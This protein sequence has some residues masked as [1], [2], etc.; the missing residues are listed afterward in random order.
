MAQ[1][2]IDIP[3]PSN[4][5]GV[6][7]LDTRTA[8]VFPDGYLVLSASWTAPDDRY[9][10]AFQALPWAEVIFR[11]AIV[12]EQFLYDRS[13]DLKIRLA[14]ES[15]YRP[16]L[17]LGFQ[18]VL[19]TGV[20]AGEYLVVSKRWRD[21]D[22]S[23]GVGWGRLGSSGTFGNPF[24][25][26]SDS[27]LTRKGFTGQGGVPLVNAW[28]HGPDVGIFGGISYQ[29]PIKNLTFKVEYT[30]DRYTSEK[31]NIGKDFSFPVNVG[32]SYRPATWL[33]LGVSLMHGRYLGVRLSTLVDPTSENWQARIDP[34]PRF[35]ARPEEPA[36]TL[37]QGEGVP[38]DSGAGAP[39]TRFIDL[40]A[41]PPLPPGPSLQS[42]VQAAPTASGRQPSSEP[43]V[44]GDA[45]ADAAL[46]DLP[47]LPGFATPPAL[48]PA[49]PLAVGGSALDAASFERIRMGLDSQ[50]L[51][52][53]GAGLE[54]DKLVVL[55]ENT[56]Y[57][58]D[59]DAISRTARI[60][61]GAAL[62][63]VEYF[64]ITMLR[65]GQ[66]LTTVTFP[67]NEIDKLAQRESSPAELFAA[68]QLE[69]ANSARLD[70]LQMNL[71]PQF[72]GQIY[73]VFRQSLFDPDQPVYMRFAVGA[74]E[75]LRLSRGWFIEASGIATIYD[76]FDKIKRQTNSELPHVRS[77]VV[78]YLQEGAVGME[79]F[80][81]SYFFKLAP[82]IFGRVTGGYLEQ[83]FAGV[84]GE[85]LY[86]PF[87]QRWAVGAD[88]FFVQQRDYNVLFDLRH[89][90]ALTGHL[91]L[92]Y[93][94]PWHDLRLAMSAGQYLAGDKG[95]TF[96]LSRRF[97]TGVQVGAWFTLTNV[98]AQKF[99]E[100]S[101]D[102]G[103]RIVI[104]FEWVAPFATQSGYELA[105]RPIQRDGG[106]RLLGD[107]ILFGLTDPS[108]YGALT[109]E[110][111][112]VFK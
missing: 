48:A 21:F 65:L 70:H 89:Y 20:Y 80:S 83:M 109:Q 72:G 51:T 55:I 50:A 73:P 108:D 76:N 17:A 8:R 54:G 94:M 36:S 12:H 79:T 64:S 105:L 90:R 100:G 22:F 78:H 104:P 42:T 92:Y 9:A 77:D 81:S 101:F 35:R 13:F 47:P 71:F 75:G 60:L 59:S 1:D 34:A 29:T 91:S 67:R 68:S 56:R 111:N 14:R 10:I 52:L 93:Q 53:M 99:G 110:W 33:D 63:D 5:G 85:L 62:P 16:E 25:L 107:T 41:Q 24:G 23:L 102:K 69:P 95:V 4:Y 82:E 84:G 30:S 2:S 43:S 18:D 44:A 28:F 40:T 38:T 58:R 112:S 57:R 106:Q 97:S 45:P 61:S 15:E 46:A 3:S 96:E 26:L 87:G 19:G 86:R 39:P 32:F 74:T 88:L 98:S 37:L 31:I 7:L 66:P 11:Y 49:A 27:F 6:G 103:I